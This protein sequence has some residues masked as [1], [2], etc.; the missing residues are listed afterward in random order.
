MRRLLPRRAPGLAALGFLTVLFSLPARANITFIVNFESSVTSD[1]NAAAVEGDINSVISLYESMITNNITVTVDFAE[2]SGGLGE[3]DTF[4]SPG[5]SYN[6]Y[7]NDLQATIGGTSV[8]TTIFGSGG[9]IGTTCGSTDPVVGN[10][11][12]D[13]KTANARAVGISLNPPVGQPDGTISLNTTAT[14]ADGCTSIGSCYYLVPVIEHE[15]DEVLG[16][17]SSEEN[18]S[19]SDGACSTTDVPVLD[20]E[21]FPEDLYRYSGNGTRTFVNANGTTACSGLGTAYFSINNG[22]TN[23]AGFNNA[24]N[25]GD[26]GDWDGA[27]VRVQNAVGSPIPS[28]PSLGVEITALE[29]IGYNFESVPEPA[30]FGLIGVALMGLALARRRRNDT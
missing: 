4:F 7:C 21:I 19:C 9:S 18:T 26:F 5:V 3:S 24:C 27:S 8:G 25:G 14:D 16:L 17:G 30:T 15:L 2:M 22:A 1:P 12:I 29:A 11:N 28:D 10:S 23:L 13:L 6:T 20:G